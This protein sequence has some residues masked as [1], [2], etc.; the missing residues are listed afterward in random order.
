MSQ[1]LEFRVNDVARLR[2][3]QRLFE[4]LK[5]DKCAQIAWHEDDYLVYFDQAALAYF[6]FPSPEEW[7]AWHHRWLATPPALRQHDPALTPRWTFGSM[8]EAIF[9]GEYALDACEMQDATTARLTFDAEAYPY[10][11]TG[12]LQALIEAFGFTVLWIDNGAEPPYQP[13]RN[14]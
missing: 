10:G 5:A 14:A 2:A 4:R 6:W 11:G 3:L 7:A 9:S 12:S 1:Y 13:Q 8:I